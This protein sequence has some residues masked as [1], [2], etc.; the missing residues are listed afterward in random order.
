MNRRDAM[1]AGRDTD[2]VDG[3]TQSEIL[4]L[5]EQLAETER[6]LAALERDH[7]RLVARERQLREES[8]HRVRNLLAIIRSVFAR[9]FGS[10]HLVEDIG[11]HFRGRLD[12]IARF[13]AP[14]G[15]VPGRSVD[16]EELIREELKNFEFDERIFITGPEVR[17]AHDIAQLL[18]LAVHELAANS[19]KFGALATSDPA[20][21]LN[22]TWT[23]ADGSMA[24]VWEESGVHVVAAAPMRRGFGR[25]FI[26]HALP[27]QIEAQT[28]FELRPGGLYCSIALP[29]R[30]TTGTVA[31]RRWL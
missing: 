10:G 14:R 29:L 4:A 30:D 25:E 20:A 15:A 31:I 24:F 6:R 23:C 9:T 3:N 11:H 17:L 2:L 18:G 8:Q 16:L 1:P 13:H 21:S 12:A 27:Y 22:V 28:R 5:R 26:E 7:A 19:I